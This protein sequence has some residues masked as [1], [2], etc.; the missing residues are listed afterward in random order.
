MPDKVPLMDS[1]VIART[2]AKFASFMNE[3]SEELMILVRA[4]VTLLSDTEPQ[5]FHNEPSHSLQQDEGVLLSV[6]LLRPT[7]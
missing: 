6:A 3:Q 4:L 1:A 5:P 7:A 2:R